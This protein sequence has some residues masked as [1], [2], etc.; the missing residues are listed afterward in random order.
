METFS[1]LRQMQLASGLGKEIEID[2]NKT[3][4]LNIS[5]KVEKDLTGIVENTKKGHDFAAR[6]FVVKKTGATLYYQ[7][8]H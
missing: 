7:T 2:L 4:F 5:W 3:P 8:E 1:K 6:V